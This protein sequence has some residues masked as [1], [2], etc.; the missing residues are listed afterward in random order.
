MKK[1]FEDYVD[2]RKECGEDLT[3]GSL[4]PLLWG[5]MSGLGEDEAEELIYKMKKDF[6]DVVVFLQDEYKRVYK[7]KQRKLG[8]A[9]KY[10]R[11]KK[12]CYTVSEAAEWLN[13]S[14]ECIRTA[15]RE[16]RLKAT[17]MGGRFL[18]TESDLLEYRNDKR[19][20]KCA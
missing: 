17:K 4:A 13:R 1:I 5:V 9:D 11:A 20:K 16:K 7:D 15:I 12:S 19:S 14:M 10:G 3:V 6:E 2:Y 8:K 18:I